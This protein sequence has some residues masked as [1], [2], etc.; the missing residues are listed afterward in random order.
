MAILSDE[1]ASAKVEKLPVWAK[2]YV[3]KLERQLDEALD[4]RDALASGSLG[5]EGTDTM[6][7]PYASQPTNLPKGGVVAF[8]L[9]VSR[10]EEVHA[11]VSKYGELTIRGTGGITIRPEASNTIVVERR[12][13]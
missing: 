9:G 11:H 8:R 3:R 6:L 10:D 5:E 12:G 13:Y 1:E 4:E 7:D 2:D